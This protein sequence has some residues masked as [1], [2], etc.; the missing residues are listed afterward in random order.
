MS[1]EETRN[2]VDDQEEGKDTPSPLSIPK[3]AV[4]RINRKIV[5]A[6]LLIFGSLAA[7]SLIWAF[8]PNKTINGKSG[9]PED[10]AKQT[11]TLPENV[12]G[13]PSSYRE[14]AAEGRTAKG[15]G[16][17]EV[18]EQWHR[19]ATTR[20]RYLRRVGSPD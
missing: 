4:S 15:V 5:M 6:L 14:L 1:D 3:I 2:K 19:R 8:S 12:V 13:S 16:E 20:V 17:R 7:L 10:S 9:K 18:R 11:P